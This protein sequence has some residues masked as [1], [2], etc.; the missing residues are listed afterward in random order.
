MLRESGCRYCRLPI[1]GRFTSRQVS[2]GYRLNMEKLANN[3]LTLTCI[4]ASDANWRS[5]AEFAHSFNGYSAWGSFEKCAEIASARRNGTLTELRTCL[6]FEERRWH[7]FGELP[8]EQAMDYIGGVL[9]KI[10][11]KVEG[12][13]FE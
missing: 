8:D 7:H 5:I 12:K 2:G 6:F 1:N 4:P 3:E 13:E 10:R 11:A 9:S